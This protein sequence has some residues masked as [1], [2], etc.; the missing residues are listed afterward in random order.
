MRKRQ[1]EITVQK[2]VCIYEQT[3]NVSETEN[4]SLSY[5]RKVI[6]NVRAIDI[7]SIYN[8]TLFHLK[9]RL[10]NSEANAFN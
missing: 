10:P 4:I 5:Q 8:A 3:N 6:Y 7:E 1:Y 2:C 9:E